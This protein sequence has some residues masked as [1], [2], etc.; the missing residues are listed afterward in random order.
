MAVAGS[1]CSNIAC[2]I[3]QLLPYLLDMNVSN[4]P[5]RE[6]MFGQE[7]LSAKSR[8]SLAEAIPPSSPAGGSQL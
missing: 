7:N 5:E 8:R 2:I 3:T 4:V 6:N 1:S